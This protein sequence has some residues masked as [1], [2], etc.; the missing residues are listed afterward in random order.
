MKKSVLFLFVSLMFP[1]IV[2][3]QGLIDVYIIDSDGPV[4]N[5][6]NAPKGKVVSTLPTDEAYVVSLV[7]VKGEWWKVDDAVLQCGDNEKTITLKGSKTGYWIHR[8]LLQFT[9]A[10]DPNGALRV[11]PS[12]KAKAVKISGDAG[13]GF[14][15]IAVKGNWIKAVSVD[16]KYTGWI[17]CDKICSNPLTTCP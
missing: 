9:I 8:S 17:H 7:S 5:I 6:R 15:P 3:A 10:G 11:A 13:G 16:R 14:H 2:C 1:F 4:T 12:A